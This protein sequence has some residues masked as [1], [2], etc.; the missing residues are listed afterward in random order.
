MNI[1][2]Y[3]RSF[4]IKKYFIS[5]PIRTPAVDVGIHSNLCNKSTFNPLNTDNK[6]LEVFKNMVFN[7][8]DRM[9]LRKV[10]DPQYI[11]KGMESLEKRKEIIIHPA[12]KEGGL[13]ILDKT[14]Y[15]AEMSQLLSD[16]VT[17]KILTKDPMLDY[18]DELHV[19]VEEGKTKG[20]LNKKEAAYFDP[21]FCS[22]PIIYCLP[23]IHKC[24][25]TWQTYHKWY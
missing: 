4:N 9:R 15:Q 12:D 21:L 6:Y 19:L 11:G 17:Y 16:H 1:H 2:K 8:L 14:Y 10:V 22:T 24:Q 25:S 5:N 7:D 13:V 20:V 3:I 18:K 23:K